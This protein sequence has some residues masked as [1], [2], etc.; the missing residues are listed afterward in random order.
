M[1][2]EEGDIGRREERRE[3]GPSKGASAGTEPSP[4]SVQIRRGATGALSVGQTVQIRTG[5]RSG[6]DRSRTAWDEPFK[7]IC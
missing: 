6:P 5:A 4:R 3:Q 7:L 1:T 2:A